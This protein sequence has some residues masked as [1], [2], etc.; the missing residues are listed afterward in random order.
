[1]VETA[2]GLL[3]GVGIVVWAFLQDLSQLQRDYPNSWQTFMAN[4]AVIQLLNARDNNT[5][6]YFSNMAGNFSAYSNPEVI[7]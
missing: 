5:S 6:D 2:F 7:G 4:T 3:R 1:M